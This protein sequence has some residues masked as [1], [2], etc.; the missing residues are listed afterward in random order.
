GAAALD[1]QRRGATESLAG[2]LQPLC[3][4]VEGAAR[5]GSEG[6]PGEVEPLAELAEVRN[7]EPRCSSWRGGAHVGGEVAERGVLL[8]ADGRDDRHWTG[9]DRADEPFV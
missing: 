1:E 7:D 9:R 8:V 5:A 4:P 3:V 2:G 6:G